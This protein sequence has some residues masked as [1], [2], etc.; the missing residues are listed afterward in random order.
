MSE[1]MTGVKPAESKAVKYS[2]KNGV[3]GLVHPFWKT[4]IT[5]DMLNDPINGPNFIKAIKHLDKQ[6]VEAK[7]EKA[8]DGWFDRHIVEGK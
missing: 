2:F 1:A 7:K 6:A 3:T 5:V 8:G 4:A